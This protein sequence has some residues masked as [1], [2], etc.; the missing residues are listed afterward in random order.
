MYLGFTKHILIGHL[1][2]IILSPQ[3]FD[4]LVFTNKTMAWFLCERNE[5]Y[6]LNGEK[7]T[8][9]KKNIYILDTIT[10]FLSDYLNKIHK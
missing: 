10:S 1:G 6:P 8:D 3:V 5:Q 7:I 2:I 9:G 4:F